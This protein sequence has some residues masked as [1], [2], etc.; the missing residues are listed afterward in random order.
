[1]G[2]LVFEPAYNGGS[3]AGSWQSWTALTG[4]WWASRPQ[5]ADDKCHPGA[6]ICS[7]SDLLGSF[8]DAVISGA[9]LFKAGSGVT[10][11]TA[12]VDAFSIRV[13]N[14]AGAITEKT[15]D[16]EHACTTLCYVDAVNGDDT[17][18]GLTPATALKTIQAGVDGVSAGGTVDVAAGT[19]VEDVHVTK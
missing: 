10:A 1:D 16:F 19:Y 3:V 18:S 6:T 8:P 7:W 2:R 15:L 13:D 9:A 14:G 5:Y 17:N 11:F 12:N 4:N